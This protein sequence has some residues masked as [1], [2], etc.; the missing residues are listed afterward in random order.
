[1]LRRSAGAVVVK[2]ETA[3][4]NFRIDP[5]LKEAAE[6]AA[7]R[8]RRSLSGLIKKLLIDYCHEQGIEIGKPK[9]AKKRE[10][11]EP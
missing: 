5:D 4:I 9:R 8:D 7:L 10:G 11:R 2:R 3:Q 6:L 1:M